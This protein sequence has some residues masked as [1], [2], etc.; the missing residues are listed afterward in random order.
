M[1]IQYLTIQ[2]PEHSKP[3]LFEHQIFNGPV[4]KRLGFSFKNRISNV[5]YEMAT[6]CRIS[7]G[8]AS[9]FQIPFQIQTICNPTSCRPIQTSPDFG[10]LLYLDL[11]LIKLI[12]G[13]GSGQQIGNINKSCPTPMYFAIPLVQLSTNCENGCWCNE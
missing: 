10:S 9:G 5:F 8:R 12:E 6:I 2:N 4:S 7:N 13:N 3:G 11:H 1:R